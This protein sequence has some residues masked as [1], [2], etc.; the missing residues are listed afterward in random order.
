VVNEDYV[1]LGD[2]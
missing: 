1:F 2:F